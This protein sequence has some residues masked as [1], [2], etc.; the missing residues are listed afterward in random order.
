MVDPIQTS[1]GTRAD[2]YDSFLSWFLTIRNPFGPSGH[3]SEYFY[4]TGQWE[5]TFF[6]NEC[7]FYILAV[8]TFLHAYRH[9]SR[10]LWLW[11]AITAHGLTVELVSYWVEPIDNFWHGQSTFMFFGQREP[12]HIILVYPAYLYIAAIAVQRSRVSELSEACLM[13]LLVIV[14]D[15]PYDVMGIKLL[16]WTWHDTDANIR[17]RHYW[18]PWT[19][20]YFHMTF[21]ASFSLIYNKARRYFTGVSGL[22]S[23]NEIERMPFSRQL[24]LKNF[25]GEFKALMCAGLFS[26]PVGILQ[27]VPGYHLGADVF[28][29]HAQFTTECLAFIYGSVALYGM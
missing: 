16:W 19:S 8:L 14:L 10:Y 1:L 2:K 20:Y 21:A 11:F 29:I 28:H 6:S 24:M 4:G 13:A 15:I 22:F 7:E 12:L 18:V 23:T 17:D 27:F 9:G 3:F 26:M 5:P 25:S